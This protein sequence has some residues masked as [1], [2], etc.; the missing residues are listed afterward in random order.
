[1]RSV[2]HADDDAASSDR[3]GNEGLIRRRGRP[4]VLGHAS[5]RRG[6]TR[7]HPQTLLAQRYVLSLPLRGK[8]PPARVAIE[9]P[10]LDEF[11][12]VSDRLSRELMVGEAKALRSYAADLIQ[13]H[14]PGV[15]ECRHVS[16]GF[17]QSRP[18]CD[19]YRQRSHARS[20]SRRGTTSRRT[21]AGGASSSARLSIKA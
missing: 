5:D 12:T 21:S 4:R 6:Q 11:A 2:G 16:I 15:Q 8:Q 7:S 1:M 9:T 13:T 14:P 18:E 20:L 3:V 10:E 19:V 17:S